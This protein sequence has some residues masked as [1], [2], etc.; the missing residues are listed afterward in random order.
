[1]DKGPKSIDKSTQFIVMIEIQKTHVRKKQVY[2]Q[3]NQI[4]SHEQ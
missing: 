1:M 4:D 2:K 3:V